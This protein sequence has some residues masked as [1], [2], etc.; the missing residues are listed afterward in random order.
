MRH[1][2]RA[3]LLILS[4]FG[5]S[6]CGPDTAPEGPLTIGG[7][8]DASMQR[9]ALAAPERPLAIRDLLGARATVFYAWSVPCPCVDAAE[10]RIQALMGGSGEGVA[11]IAVDGEP[12]DT[13]EQVRAKSLRLGSP[14]RI[15]LDPDQ[16]LCRLLGFDSAM[17][18]AVLD[19]EHRLVY[20]GALDGDYVEGRGEYLAEALEAVLN[21]RE[22][23][24]PERPRTYGCFFGDPGSCTQAR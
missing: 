18:V 7:V 12:L 4:A 16:G 13:A 1:A 14:Y 9:P 23:P 10:P 3:V 22:P 6:A 8:L 2:L 24:T 17:Q 20:R 11:W 5:A 19:A 15:L 21:G